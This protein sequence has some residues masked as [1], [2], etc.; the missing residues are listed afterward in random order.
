MKST[1][2]LYS[3]CF[4]EISRLKNDLAAEQQTT[5]RLL[6]KNEKL[7][8]DM[9]QLKK[10]ISTTQ[11]NHGKKKLARPRVDFINSIC[12]LRPCKN[13]FVMTLRGMMLV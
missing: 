11:V 2:D 1:P 7:Q 4:Q 12:A 6:Q 5:N 8:S 13:H 3:F 10:N 9:A